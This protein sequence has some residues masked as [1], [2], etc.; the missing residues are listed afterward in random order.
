[1]Y[2]SPEKLSRQDSEPCAL[3]MLLLPVHGRKY[4]IS[5]DPRLIFS[6]FSSLDIIV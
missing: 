4:K 3:N 5:D 2:R 6:P 1:M